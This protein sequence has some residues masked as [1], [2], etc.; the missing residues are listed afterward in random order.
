MVLPRFLILVGALELAEAGSAVQPWQAFFD[1]PQSDLR[2]QLDKAR[3][4]SRRGIVAMYHFDE[5]PGC[6]QMKRDVLSSLAVQRWYRAQFVVLAIDTR[7]E[8]SV[9]GFDGATRTEKEHARSAQVFATPSFDF[10]DLEGA[11]VYRQVGGIYNAAEFVLLG[12]YV[13]TGASASQSF[14]EFKRS[15]KGH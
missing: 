5:C 10:Y 1:P 2:L 14:E 13:A 15:R 4:E 11:R 9:I 7:G 12:Q 6:N 3:A 8:R